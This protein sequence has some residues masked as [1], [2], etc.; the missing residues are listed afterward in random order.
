MNIDHRYKPSASSGAANQKFNRSLDNCEPRGNG[1]AKRSSHLGL[2]VVGLLA[3]AVFAAPAV[4]QAASIGISI[5]VGFAPPAIPVYTQP[6]CPAPGYMWTPGYWAYDPAGG[7]YWV[8]GTWV[9]APA[10]GLLWTP[11]YWGWSGAAF[12]WNA[13]YWGPHI[14]FYGGINYGFGYVGVGFVGGEWRGGTFFYNRAVTN[15]SGPRFVNVYNRT[16]VNNFAVNRVS[17][18]GGRGGLTAR[19]TPGELAAA[20]DRHI[21]ATALQRQHDTAARNDRAQ[22][23][24]ANHGMPGVAATGR[25]GDFRGA[26][27]VRAT[28]AGGPVPAAHPAANPG[29]ANTYSGARGPNPGGGG[30]H[31][32]MTAHGNTPASHNYSGHPGGTPSHNTPAHA[33]GPTHQ[34]ESHQQPAKQASK[35]SGG[36][37]S[38]ERESEPRR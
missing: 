20:R 36:G 10:P 16:V 13:G 17:Y 6:P 15:F 2:W 37:H 38:N 30:T 7:Y 22:F 4:S 26:G 32:T 3:L 12:V 8:P 1:T 29:H 28:R 18:N 24:S 31:Q 34:A 9:A 11:G 14:G 21:E 23:A 5:S 33:T 35:P 19:P 25:A 27:V